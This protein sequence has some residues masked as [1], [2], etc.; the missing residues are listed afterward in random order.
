MEVVED[1][2]KINPA[3]ENALLAREKRK[4]VRLENAE[5]EGELINGEEVAQKWQHIIYACKTRFL[6]IGA[7]LAPVLPVKTDPHEIKEMIDAAVSEA[8]EELET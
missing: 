8:L 2:S 3:I 5:K 6:A 1:E 4:K 7:R